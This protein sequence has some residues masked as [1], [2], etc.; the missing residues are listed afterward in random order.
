MAS[1]SATMTRFDARLSVEQKR[2][3]EKAAKLEGYR[4][5]TDFV[6]KILQ[7]EAFA[8]IEKHSATLASERDKKIFFNA[9]ISPRKPNAKLRAA[10]RKYKKAK[11]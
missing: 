9:L 10:A 6:L 1:D 4:S 3:F 11:G 5:L 8:I 7:A 2:I